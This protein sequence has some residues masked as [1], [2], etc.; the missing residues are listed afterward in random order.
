MMTLTH[1]STI[2]Q[3]SLTIKEQVLNL[4]Q[5]SDLDYAEFQELQG[6]VYLKA[7]FGNTPFVELLPYQSL[8][9]KWWINHW[10]KR[11]AAFLKQVSHYKLPLKNI[12]IGYEAHHNPN[13]VCFKPQ[14]VILRQSYSVM[15]GNL[16]KAVQNG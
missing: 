3:K 10:L 6:Y 14:A 2:E 13:K 7:E 15:I 1:T 9:W 4:L 11:D 12:R 5:W 16:I 8:F